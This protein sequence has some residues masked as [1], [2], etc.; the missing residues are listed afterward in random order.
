MKALFDTNVVVSAFATEGLCSKILLR[1]GRG[2]FELHTCPFILGELKEKLRGKLSFTNAEVKE[3]LSLIRD[4]S[5][6]VDPDSAGIE[7]RGICKDRDDDKVLACAVAAGVDC[8]VT[9]DKELL[10]LGSYK[11]IRIM[12]PRDFEMLFSD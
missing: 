12:S 6:A 9:G 5:A 1:A 7:V 8:I 3:A 2:E 4:I 11:G 10:G